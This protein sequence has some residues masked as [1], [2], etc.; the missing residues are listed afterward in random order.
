M[1]RER[2]E[3][4]GSVLG[5]LWKTLAYLAFASASGGWN[6]LSAEQE[7]VSGGGV[8]GGRFKLQIPVRF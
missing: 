5:F 1:R 3:G 7:R 8:G 6:S 2:R 4:G